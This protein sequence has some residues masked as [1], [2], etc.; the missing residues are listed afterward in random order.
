MLKFWCVLIG[1]DY[2]NVLTYRKSSQEKIILFGSMLLIP[3]TLWALN[4]YMMSREIFGMGIIGSLGTAIVLGFII[5]LIERSIIL[6]QS[7]PTIN[8]LRVILGLIVAILGSLTMDEVIFKND[9]DNMMQTYK[10]E[11]VDNE[12]AKWDSLYV[13]RIDS[14]ARIVNFK[15]SVYKQRSDEYALELEGKANSGQG[16]DG[17]LAKRKEILMNRSYDDLVRDQEVLKGLEVEYR[18]NR[19]F[20]KKDARESFND[21]GLLMRMKAMFRLILSDWVSFIV[22]LLYFLLVLIMETLVIFMK[23]FTPKSPD[24]ELEEMGDKLLVSKHK[25]MLEDRRNVYDLDLG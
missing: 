10:V 8:R 4:G 18:T 13:G 22:F 3:V 12:T 14:V 21:K 24:E 15:S 1:K 17:P 19:E 7:N 25:K 6:A 20:S 5:Y 16:G 23:K 9:I 2:D 11:G